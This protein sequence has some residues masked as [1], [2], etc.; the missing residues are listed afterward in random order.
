LVPI[1][2][3]EAVAIVGDASMKDV[4]ILNELRGIRRRLAEQCGHDVHCYAAMLQEFSDTLPGV[5]VNRPLLLPQSPVPEE[6][7]QD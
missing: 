7:A 6:V 4:P 2:H 3:G 5:Y 1:L